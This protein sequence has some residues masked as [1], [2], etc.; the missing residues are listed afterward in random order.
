MAGETDHVLLTRFNLPSAGAESFIR[1]REGWLKHRA[2][3][4]ERYC[5]PSVLAQTSQWFHWIVYF[6]P[7]SPDWLKCRIR[8][9]AE[10]RTYVPIFRPAVSRADLIDDISRVTGR[11]GTHLMTTNLDNDDGLA[12]NF[13]SRLQAVT[14]GPDRMAIYLAR[15][16]IKSGTKI[17]LRLD[18]RNA[19]CSVVDGWDSPSTCWAD[20][21]T[22]LGKNMRVLELYD[23]PGWL[24]VV[25]GSNV[26]N[27]VRGR[28]ISPSGYA[29]LF[30]GL[31]DDVPVPRR[32]T[33][34]SDLLVAQPR[35]MAEEAGRA[36]A[37]GVAMRLLGKEGLNRAKAI[38]GSRRAPAADDESF[39]GDG[40]RR[41]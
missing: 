12:V 22:L 39:S 34:A 4:F 10:K 17:Y 8:E 16:L 27:R 30:P 23:E 21:H 35:R 7:E 36:L 31:M 13:V 25:H 29:G 1:S 6:D 38:L 41:F 37:K 3:L 9:H 24:Q 20:W 11:A 14:P 2:A 18:K 28:L 5:L 33:M 26:S 15:G 40:A 19:F 32:A